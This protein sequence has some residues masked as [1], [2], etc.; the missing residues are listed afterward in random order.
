MGLYVEFV[1]VMI[2]NS[3]KFFSGLKNEAR[4]LPITITY[5][6]QIKYLSDPLV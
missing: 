1:E 5:I 3:T 4:V 6:E 2:I